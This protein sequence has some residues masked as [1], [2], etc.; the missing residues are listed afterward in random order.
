MGFQGLRTGAIAASMVL[1]GCGGASWS[2]I[3]DC[4]KLSA[5]A[6]ADECW[7]EYAPDVFREDP[8]RGIEIVEQKI[9]DPRVQDFVWLTVTRE[10]D[11]GS[12][13]YCDRIEEEALAE[14]C[15]VLV[16]RPHLH[17]E[18]IKGQGGGPPQGGPP[19][20]GPPAGGPPQ[21]GPPPGGGPPPQGGPPPGGEAPTEGTPTEA[22]GTAGE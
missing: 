13:K 4:E 7:A 2:S 11:P 20:G 14:R 12:Y 1:V 3:D 15:R 5:G 19:G 18:L 6:K 21:G 10:V 17:R 16:S 9:Q 22:A 8:A